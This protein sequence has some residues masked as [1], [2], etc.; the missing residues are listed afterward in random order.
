MVPQHIVAASHSQ[1]QLEQ[2][3]LQPQHPEMVQRHSGATPQTQAVQPWHSGALLAAM[4][5]EALRHLQGRTPGNSGGASAAAAARAAATAGAAAEDE[6]GVRPWALP[7]ARAGL[8]Q[9][10]VPGAV[11]LTDAAQVALALARMGFYGDHHQ[12]RVPASAAAAAAGS[13]G[14]GAAPAAAAAVAG[15]AKARL[16]ALQRIARSRREAASEQGPAVALSAAGATQDALPKRQR[17][18]LLA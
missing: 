7:M 14:G 1:A 18:S 12:S 8:V 11:M 15:S 10:A 5:H 6:G 16:F 3:G 17:A 4:E 9:D 2:P 13:G